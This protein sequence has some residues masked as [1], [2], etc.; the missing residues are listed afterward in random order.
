[1]APPAL[2]FAA[3]ADPTR[4]AILENLRQGGQTAGKIASLFDISWPAISRHLRILKAA[5]LVWE[6]RDGRSR[7]YELNPDALRPALTWLTK[8][9]AEPGL[10]IAV[11]SPSPS[12]VGREYTS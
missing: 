12:Q 1:M 11:T 4:R 5:S 6:S 3:L 8:F 2:I 9:R 10:I 7:Y